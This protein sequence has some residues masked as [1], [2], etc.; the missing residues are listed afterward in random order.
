MFNNLLL[1]AAFAT[2]AFSMSVPRAATSSSSIPDV[3]WKVS[4]FTRRKLGFSFWISFFI[5]LFLFVF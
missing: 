5:F 3:Q 4:G 2:S 1:V